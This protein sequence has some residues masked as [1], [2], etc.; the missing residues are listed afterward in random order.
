MVFYA[1]V[2]VA[3]VLLCAG[4]LTFYYA[5]FLDGVV[6]QHKRRLW[7]LERE[8]AELERALEGAR[9]TLRRREEEAWPEVVDEDDYRVR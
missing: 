5:L 6:R 7:E 3:L 8:N 4:A 9:A 2:I 1:V